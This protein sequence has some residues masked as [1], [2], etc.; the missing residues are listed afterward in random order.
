MNKTLHRSTFALLLFWSCAAGAADRLK[1]YAVN[2]PLAYFAQ[3]VGAEHIDVILPVPADIDPAFWKPGA[4]DIVGLQQADLILLNGA[5]YAKWLKHASL[6]HR[7][8]VNTSAAFEQD[9][10]AVAQTVTHRHGPGG[11]HS[12][13]GTA[14]TTWLD[15]NQ[16]VQQLAAVR[17]AL[18]DRLPELAETFSR[19]AEPLE[20]ELLSLDGALIAAVNRNPDRRFVASHPV[21]QYLARRYN[22]KLE[23]VMWEADILPDQ[24]QWQALQR[25]LEAHPAQWMVWEAEPDERSVERLQALGLRSLVFDP[26]ANIPDEGDFISVMKQ[27]IMELEKAFGR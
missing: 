5:D 16:A 20:Q 25:L 19:N 21:Y 22:I 26:C 7:K 24:A 10:I 15:L 23:S 12:H 18:A 6:P 9:L 2:Y 27:N 17:V 13:A 1:V 3:R 14:F 11:E 8:M 4:D